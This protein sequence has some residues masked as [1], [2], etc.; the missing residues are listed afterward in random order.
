MCARKR[1]LDLIH[2]GVHFRHE[3]GDARVFDA[4]LVDRAEN[5]GRQDDAGSLGRVGQRL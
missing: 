3:I 5:A 1:L 4:V 2:V